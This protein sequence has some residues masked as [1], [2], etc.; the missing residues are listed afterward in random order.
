M[1]RE[2]VIAI[3]RPKQ[4]MDSNLHRIIEDHVP[5][6]RRLGLATDYPA[7]VLKSRIDGALV[8]F[9]EWKS[10][11]AVKAAHEHSE[12]LKMWDEFAEVCDY[13]SLASLKEAGKLFAHFDF[14]GQ[15]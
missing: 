3:Y 9:F 14:V 2:F 11:E 10:V 8:E 4:G 6:L 13:G 1:P 7:T 5:K 15:F 12:V